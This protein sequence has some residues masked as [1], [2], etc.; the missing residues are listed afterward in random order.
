[1]S[2]LLHR[3]EEIQDF[4]V[5]LKIKKWRN[6]EMKKKAMIVVL[7]SVFALVGLLG[8]VAQAVWYTCSIS[9]VGSTGTGYLVEA[10]DTAAQPAFTKALF[11]LDPY[12]GKGK[13][14]YAAALT[15][16][17]NST[18]CQLF[19]DTFTPYSIAWG[20]LATK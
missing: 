9:Y 13:E 20:C 6:G 8:S 19:V 3:R 16:F 4:R 5:N 18:N 17:A 12:S 10:T 11:V 14:M 7:V 2:E 15:A 1:L